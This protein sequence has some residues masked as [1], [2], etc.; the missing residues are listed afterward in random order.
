[1]S[2]TIGNVRETLRSKQLNVGKLELKQAP[3]VL[4]LMSELQQNEVASIEVLTERFGK[5]TGKTQNPYDIRS[6]ISR[7]NSAFEQEIK[8]GSFGSQFSIWTPCTMA[9]CNKPDKPHRICPIKEVEWCSANDIEFVP[10]YAKGR[11]VV[12]GMTPWMRA[13]VFGN[14]LSTQQLFESNSTMKCLR[15][16]NVVIRKKDTTNRKTTVRKKPNL[17]PPSYSSLFDEGQSSFF[18]QLPIQQQNQETTSATTC[19]GVDQDALDL[20]LKSIENDQTLPPQVLQESDYGNPSVAFNELTFDPVD[21]ND[22][23]AIL[24]L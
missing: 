16:N 8:Q 15:G 20:L 3:Y 23:N 1:M 7:L 2:E 22:I 10:R 14:S 24:G 21:F 5:I 9:G 17:P 19:T 6:M 18:P 4:L 13:C 12:Y 11:H